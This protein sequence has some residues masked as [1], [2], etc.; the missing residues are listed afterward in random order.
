[1]PQF[2]FAYHGGKTP[3]SEEEGAKVM[4]AW[5]AWMG[6]MGEALAV[7]GAPVGMSKT[8][9]TT[10]VAEDGGANPISGYSVVEAADFTAAC[11]MAKGC[12]LVVDGSGSVE[13]AEIMEM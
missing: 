10:G 12:P 6:G 2:I 3:E 1:M 8:V 11:D 4:A 5:Q 13:V 9:T 7:P